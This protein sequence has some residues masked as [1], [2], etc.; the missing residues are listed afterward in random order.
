VS[1]LPVIDRYLLRQMAG[2]LLA[3]LLVA[4]LIL[5]IERAL[6]LL[7]T[8]L[9]ARGSIRVLLEMLTYLVPHYL[10][11]ALPL[12]VFLAVLLTFS[13]LH[14]DHEMDALHAAGI[15][16]FRLARPVVISALLA[17]ALSWSVFNYR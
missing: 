2:P 13:R 1:V 11:L 15:S 16:L 14:R 7:D 9:A 5:L 12:S 17:V 6:R 8:V 4:L 10:G 3:T